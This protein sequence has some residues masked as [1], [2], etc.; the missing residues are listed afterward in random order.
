MED[1]IHSFTQLSVGDRKAALKRMKA[2][3]AGPSVESCVEEVIKEVF[4][5]ASGKLPQMHVRCAWHYGV[6]D[7]V[8]RMQ[9]EFTVLL[10]GG[11]VLVVEA[12]ESYHASK[13]YDAHEEMCR[14][15]AYDL[16]ARAAF[17]ERAHIVVVR[18][19]AKGSRLL[20][21]DPTLRHLAA[22]LRK[23]GDQLEAT[24]PTVSLLHFVEYPAINKHTD[25][26]RRHSMKEP[27]STPGEGRGAPIVTYEITAELTARLKVRLRR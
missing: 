12:D 18:F 14:V 7:A 10:R 15:V 19:G 3:T 1:I 21:T 17:G 11:T 6:S 8:H 2:I 24:P 9:P 27:V 26:W 22:F 4:V 25:E 16:K 20:P 23:T 5:G 13:K